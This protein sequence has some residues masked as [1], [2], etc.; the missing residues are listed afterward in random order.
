[1][2]LTLVL[3]IALTQ[4]SLAPDS[5]EVHLRNLRQLTFG[6]QNAEAYFS[7]SGRLL[8]FQ[9]QGPDEHCDQMYIMGADGSGPHRVSS[10]LGRTTCGYF[11]GHGTRIF[12]PS[13]PHSPPTCPP[14]PDYLPGYA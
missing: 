10:G 12:Y 3:V 8:I 4:A 7:A 9:R 2:L 14:R 5:G 11:H 6:G 1:M 13:T